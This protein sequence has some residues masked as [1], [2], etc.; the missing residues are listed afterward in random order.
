M[1]V[2]S[3][4]LHTKQHHRITS[5]R[6]FVKLRQAICHLRTY[7]EVDGSEI[8][9][10]VNDEL[11]N[12]FKSLLPLEDYPK[13]QHDV[14]WILLNIA[15]EHK[16]VD[17][18]YDTA[19]M[20]HYYALL[21]TTSYALQH[22]ALWILAIGART[23][24]ELRNAIMS[25]TLDVITNMIQSEFDPN[26]CTDYGELP[27]EYD[28]LMAMAATVVY[29]FCDGA[30]HSIDEKHKLLQI[31]ECLL[32]KYGTNYKETFHISRDASNDDV[33]EIR[34]EM[35]WSLSALLMDE[36]DTQLMDF[37]LCD[38]NIMNELIYLLSSHN[39]HI[40][41]GAIRTFG[42]LLQHTVLWDKYVSIC[43]TCGLLPVL[44]QCMKNEDMVQDICW[45]LSKIAADSIKSVQALANNDLLLDCIELM[46]DHEDDDISTQALN[47]LTNAVLHGN[48]TMIEHLVDKGLLDAMIKMDGWIATDD[49]C[50]RSVLDCLECMFCHKDNGQQ[51]AQL[52]VEGGGCEFLQNIKE[53]A[54]ETDGIFTLNEWKANTLIEKYFT[55]NNDPDWFAFDMEYIAPKSICI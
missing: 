11:L 5:K 29:M 41:D 12:H 42:S 36:E 44:K 48:E 10:V 15:F 27:Q 54:T 31:I 26:Q 23:S 24:I 16:Y 40:M 18:I 49:E 25:S 33:I 37:I 35:V 30:Q 28:K 55:S 9:E 6:H 51:Y 20:D 46:T 14:L 7:V 2:I 21:N 34:S 50:T 52:F 4:P 17:K 38:S 19:F 8:A 53:G 3:Q 22:H 1:P 32:S 13:V 47:T 43:I 39:G 45:L